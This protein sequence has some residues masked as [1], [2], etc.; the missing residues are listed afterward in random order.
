MIKLAGLHEI[1]LIDK[2]NR[3][4]YREVG[5]NNI[6]NRGRSK[7]AKCSGWDDNLQLRSY[8]TNTGYMYVGQG[9]SHNISNEQFDVPSSSPYTYQLAHPT[10]VKRGTLVVDD[11]EGSTWQEVEAGS[12]EQ[13]K[14]SFDFDTGTVTFHSDDA[15]ETLYAD[16]I[17]YTC[18]EAKRTDTDLEGWLA[19][20]ALRHSPPAHTEIS[21]PPFEV[22]YEGL[23]LFNE[24]TGI[25][26]ESGVG[27]QSDRDPLLNRYVLTSPIEKDNEHSLLYKCTIRIEDDSSN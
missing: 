27:W 23:F 3:I 2:R 25:I 19:S 1:M 15:E 22:E 18:G 13:G 24:A 7:L 17:Y 21:T 10:G 16:Y 14:Y 8:N 4:V 5:K 9:S 26:M 11:G 20:K 6:T 12:E